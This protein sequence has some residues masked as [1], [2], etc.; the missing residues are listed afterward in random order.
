MLMKFKYVTEELSSVL[1]VGGHLTKVTEVV[2][3]RD[4]FFLFHILL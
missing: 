4:T 3:V 1:L 2:H